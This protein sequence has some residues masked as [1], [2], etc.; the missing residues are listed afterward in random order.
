LT[1]RCPACSS[2]YRQALTL[3]MSNFFAPA[4]WPWTL[5]PSWG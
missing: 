4:S 2:E 3:D 5:T 1:I